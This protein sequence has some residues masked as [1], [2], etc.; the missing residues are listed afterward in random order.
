MPG[1]A[2]SA[3]NTSMRHLTFLKTLRGASNIRTSAQAQTRTTCT[4]CLAANPAIDCSVQPRRCLCRPSRR[5]RNPGTDVYCPYRQD[6]DNE[7]RGGIDGLPQSP[8][9]GS[10]DDEFTITGRA[11]GSIGGPFG[12][13]RQPHHVTRFTARLLRCGYSWCVVMAGNLRRFGCWPL[14]VWCPSGVLL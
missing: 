10:F 9:H 8:R 3:V 5:T 2:E 12:A 11:R 7:R 14:T 4:D 6:P 1:I 13:A